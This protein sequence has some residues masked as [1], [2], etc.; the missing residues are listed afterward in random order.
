MSQMPEAELEA[1]KDLARAELGKKWS[2][3][4]PG[5]IGEKIMAVVMRRP[6]IN[7]RVI[8]L[9]G[10][11]YPIDSAGFQ[12]AE[13]AARKRRD[14]LEAG[15]KAL[16]GEA[17]ESRIEV[18]GPFGGVNGRSPFAIVRVQGKNALQSLQRQRLGLT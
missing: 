6:E 5:T 10:G 15:F 8:A 2:Q 14:I 1:A 17:A 9:T 12:Q 16:A 4:E 18:S 7:R 13:S 11:P 3:E